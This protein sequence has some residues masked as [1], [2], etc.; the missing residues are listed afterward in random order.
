[1][2]SVLHTYARPVV[3]GNFLSFRANADAAVQG[4]SALI[5]TTS[6]FTEGLGCK[7]RENER[8]IASNDLCT[9]LIIAYQ[10]SFGVCHIIFIFFASLG[11]SLCF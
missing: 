10:D 8:D 1:M 7:W 5:F 4:L 11:I 3:V 2:I 6:G 9:D